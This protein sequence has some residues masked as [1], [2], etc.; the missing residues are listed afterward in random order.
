MTKIKGLLAIGVILLFLGVI[1]NPVT[2]QLTVQDKLQEKIEATSIGAVQQLQLTRADIVSMQKFLPDLIEKMSTATSRT[3]LVDIVQSFIGQNGRHPFLV[4]LLSLTIKGIDFNYKINQLRP[5]RK[6]VFIMS[7]GFTNKFLSLGKNKLN[8]VRPS[9][10]WFYSGRSNLILN[11]RTIII[12]PYPFGIKMF[13]G[14]QIGFMT[15]FKGLYIHRSGS[16]ADKAITM[17]FGFTSTVRGFDLSPM[18]K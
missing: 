7:W 18:N 12:D 4:F 5:L 17:F 16:I 15:D 13:T 9:T 3:N 11:S 14:R 10:F 2:A 6:N 1:F 8:I